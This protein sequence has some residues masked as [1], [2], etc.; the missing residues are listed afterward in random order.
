MYREKGKKMQ[1]ERMDSQMKSGRFRYTDKSSCTYIYIT[2]TF[3]A[4]VYEKY[5]KPG[6]KLYSPFTRTNPN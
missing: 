5:K 6:K 1:R 2:R 4:P 3:R